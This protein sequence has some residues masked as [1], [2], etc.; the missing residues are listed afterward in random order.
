MALVERVKNI[1]LAPKAEWPKIA[2]EAATTQSL[3]VGYV[4]I[5]AAIGPIAMLLTGPML[6]AT[7]AILSYLVSLAVTYLLA[8]IVDA[9][10]PTFGGEKNFV[11]SLKL[12]AY[13]YTAAWLG[14]IFQLLGMIGGVLGLLATIYSFYTFYLGVAG[15]KKC[16]QDKAVVYTIVVVICGI[17]LGVLLGGVLM[18]ALVGGSMMG[19]AGMG[20]MR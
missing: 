12:T 3:Y 20:A 14:G 15:L 9:L 10:A 17:A 13:S 11:Q 4:M 7:V 1:L 18:S 2:E 5:L 19:A 6:M 8:L 16:P